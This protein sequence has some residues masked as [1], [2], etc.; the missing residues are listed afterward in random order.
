MTLKPPIAEYLNSDDKKTIKKSL[1]SKCHDF[2]DMY[3]CVYMPLNTIA[4][5]SSNTLN[6]LPLKSNN[7]IADGFADKKG[8][9]TSFL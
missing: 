5:K 7:S 6:Y 9:T 1:V 2:Q 8:K 4:L 3:M